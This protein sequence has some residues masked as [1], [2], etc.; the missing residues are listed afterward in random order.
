MYKFKDNQ[1][2][3]TDFGAAVGLKLNQENR[4]IKKS[5]SIPWEEIELRYAKLFTNKK[6]NVAKPLRL[7]LGAC[8][9][10]AEYGFS[11]EE[12]ANMIQ[13]HAYFQYFCGYREYDDSKLPF[14]PSLMVYFRKRL[15]PEVLGE[16]NEMIIDKAQPV[17]QEKTDSNDNDD[18]PGNRGTMIIDATCAPS[19]IKYPQ[20]TALLNE[21]RESAEKIIDELFTT[22]DGVKPRTYRKEAHKEYLKFARSRKRTKSFVRKAIK[23]QLGYLSRDIA[24]I[25]AM[26]AG[27]KVLSEK[28][29]NRLDTIRKV[30][31][32]QKFMYDQQTHSV[33]NRIVSLSRPFIRPIVR[34]KAGKPVEFGAK[35]DISVSDGWARL[36]VLSFDAYNEALN[37]KDMVERYRARTGRYP[38]RILADKIYRNR[39]NLA[40]CKLHHIRLSG[41]AL[42][43][44]KKD[45][46]RD[47]KQDYRDEC[48]RV[49]VERRF[50]LAKRKCGMGL[51]MT[52]L[53]ETISHS[54]AMSVLV[55]NL[56]KIQHTILQA[57]LNWLSAQGFVRKFAFVQ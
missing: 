7:A 17:K 46:S 44:P 22:G 36:E 35:L 19:N 48:E 2:S 24:H 49:E 55:L 57:L 1:L 43:R 23:K 33:E 11:D 8:I 16:I 21:A 15:T 31:T 47:K 53:E 54:I 45:E 32:Q 25:D 30:Y 40:F 34:G 27:G 26:L 52:K 12:T 41:P 3:L 39:D 51:I 18:D 56:R 14:D 37:L 20:D 10:Q 50:S 42:G 6:G 28:H 5:R 9:L 13:E 38:S 29:L 4:W